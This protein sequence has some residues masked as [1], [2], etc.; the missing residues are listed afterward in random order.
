MQSL[1]HTGCGS[2]MIGKRLLLLIC[3]LLPQNWSSVVPC[4]TIESEVVGCIDHVTS[5]R[6]WIS[7]DG[8][9]ESLNGCK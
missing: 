3:E 4:P 1:V 5:L 8:P 6:S 2:R 9:T 7:P